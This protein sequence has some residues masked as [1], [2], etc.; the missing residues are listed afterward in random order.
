MRRESVGVDEHV[1]AKVAITD[2]EGG[3]P[4][5]AIRRVMERAGPGE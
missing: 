3:I 2:P 5:E 4:L 1:P